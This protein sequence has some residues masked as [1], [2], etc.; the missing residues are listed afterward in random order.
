MKRVDSHV[1]Q[2]MQRDLDV[3]KHPSNFLYDAR[4]IRLTAREGDTMLAITNEKGTA[5]TKNNTRNIFRSLLIE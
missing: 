1:F 2:G 3:A 4:N 5:D